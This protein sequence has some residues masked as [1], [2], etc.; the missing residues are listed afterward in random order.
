[1]RSRALPIWVTLG[2]VLLLIVL[3]LV[4]AFDPIEHGVRIVFLPVARVVSVV[5]ASVRNRLFGS[6]GE[7]VLQE[8]NTELEARV[9]ALAVDYVRLRA[10]EEEN[11]SLQALVQYFQTS[12]YD[13]VSARIIGRSIDPRSATILIDRGS[14][15]GLESGMA[16]VVDDGVFVGKITE[17]RD[18]VSIVTLVSD[19][20]SRI[21]ASRAG[22]QGLL[23]LVEGRGNGVAQLTLVPQAQE[24]K[25]NDVIV[26][27]G[28]EDKIPA[29]LTI[30][31][32]NEIEGKPTDP[33]QNAALEPFARMDRLNL[34]SVLRPTALRP[35]E[36]KSSGL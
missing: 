23:G 13:Q 17:L 21:A 10:L 7:A 33:F 5:G 31:L 2:S 14:H 22:R 3:R 20:R 12:G 30:G 15:D 32:I 1:M 29:N 16:V 8:R 19:E 18:R 24:M 36:E 6:P 11:R 28:T 9:S 34:V 35:S 4:G 25:R 26:T 27:A